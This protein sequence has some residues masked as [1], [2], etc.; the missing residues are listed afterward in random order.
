MEIHVADFSG[1]CFGVKRA[2][3]LAESSLHNS[4]NALYSLGPLIH[5]PQTVALLEAQGI[6]SIKDISDVDSGSLILRS[7]GVTPDIIE[8]AEN[9]G[10]NIIDATCPFVKRA[11]ELARKTYQEGLQVV[12]VGDVNHP[13]VIGLVGWTDGVAIVVENSA[14]AKQVSEYPE[15][16]VIAQTTQT[17]E[18]FS[19]VIEVLRNRAKDLIVYN[20]ICSATRDRQQAAK[21]MACNVDLM[22]V[23][24]GKNSSNTQKLA[25]VCSN[26]GTPTYHIESA[27]EINPRWFNNRFKVGVTAGASTPNWIIEEVVERMKEFNEFEEANE[28]EEEVAAETG[29]T[30]EPQEIASAPEVEEDDYAIEEIGVSH[31]SEPAAEEADTAPSEQADAIDSAIDATSE[32]VEAHLA[33]N[34]KPIRRGEIVTGTVV[35]VNENEVL[36]DVGGKSEGIIPLGELSLV[37]SSNP[38]EDIN[39]GDELEVQV[40]RVENEDGN[41][42]LS[43][44]RADR[45]IAWTNLEEAFE[46][47]TELSGKVIEVVRGGLL[48]DVGIR[49]FV[50]ASLVERGYVADLNQYL[51]TELRLRVIELD[52]GKN[53]IVLS[54]KA[55]LDEEYEEKRQETWENLEK[56][57]TRPGIVRR[58]TNF[59]AFVDLGGVD[60]LLHVSE[61]AW[62]RVEHPA[63]VLSEGQELDVYVLGVDREG[64]KVSLGLKQLQRNPWETAAE[65]YLSGSIVE[66]KVLRIAPFGA[67]V[68]VEPGIEGLVHI[69]QL[70]DDHVEKTEDVVSIGQVV[71]VKVLSVDPEAQ[72][73][74]LSIRQATEKEEKKQEDKPRERQERPEKQ[75]RQDRPSRPARK[76]ESA[77]PTS[78]TEDEGGFTL[79]DL[80]DKDIFGVLE[81]VEDV[82]EVEDELDEE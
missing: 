31:S 7:H 19:A 33:Q 65:K 68:E 15:I 66:G 42:V 24:G 16:A 64:G 78:Y 6:K 36:V 51:D 73:M 75:A 17:E 56:G 39:V 45:R 62:G 81:D 27:E 30:E 70:A 58:L 37:H 76:R 74:S 67:F 57:Q 5:N 11:Q 72:R 8:A 80:I 2:I 55:I 40:L 9:K 63:D 43:K 54:Q 38:M 20:T 34:L 32:E 71:P 48:V 21:D 3:E 12:V 41:P 77:G 52:R 69:S 49:G 44:K 10:L 59:G 79:G 4:S 53:K 13:E 82:E 60:G 46:N 50:P 28:I 26:T 61:I 18:N 29:N 47:E 25:K 23:V 22:V 14:A 35:Q 1:F